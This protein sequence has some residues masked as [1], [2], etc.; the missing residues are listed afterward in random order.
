MENDF[1]DSVAA[2]DLTLLI[3]WIAVEL[4]KVSPSVSRLQIELDWTSYTWF[5]FNLIPLFNV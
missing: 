5:T 1:I 2:V 3:E 4:F